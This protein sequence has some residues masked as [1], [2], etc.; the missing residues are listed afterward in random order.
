M[1]YEIDVVEIVDGTIH[2]CIA[3]NHPP[4][5]AVIAETLARVLC[6]RGTASEY[7]LCFAQLLILT[8]ERVEFFHATAQAPN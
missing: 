4:Y 5:P 1:A 8:R 2:D 6:Q 7:S 3:A